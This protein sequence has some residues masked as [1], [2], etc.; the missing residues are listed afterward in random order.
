MR[1]WLMPLMAVVTGCIGIRYESRIEGARLAP[2]PVSSV[3]QP[4]ASRPMALPQVSPGEWVDLFDGK[5]LDGWRVLKEKAFVGHAEVRVEDGAI[6]LRRGQLQTGIGWAGEF[7]RDNYEVSLEA[8][9]TEGYDFFCGMTFPVGDEP[10]T[11]IVGGW[12]GMVVGLSNVDHM[13][14]AE[15]V[16]T[17]SMRFEEKRWYP[18][19]LRVTSGKIEVWIDDSQMIGLERSGHRF[20]VWWEQE[21]ARPFGIATWDTGAALRRIR[22]RSLPAE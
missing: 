18:I 3:S 7:P 12:G 11:L 4:A 2:D 10:C 6:V 5:T 1:Y 22:L 17:T 19:R 9:R 20:D 21:A 13:H 14:A 8:M 16:T 15:N